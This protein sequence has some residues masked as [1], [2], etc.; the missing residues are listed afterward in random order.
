MKGATHFIE[1]YKTGNESE[2]MMTMLNGIRHL[3]TSTEYTKTDSNLKTIAV[4]FIKPKHSALLASHDNEV[5]ATVI[6]KA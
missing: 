1:L 6:E 2:L 5:G 3:D 4:W